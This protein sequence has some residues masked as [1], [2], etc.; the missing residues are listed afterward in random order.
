[1][2]FFNFFGKTL[3][4]PHTEL[5]DWGRLHPSVLKIKYLQ[6]YYKNPR[7]KC[8]SKKEKQP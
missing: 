8:A 4:Y 3:R 1:V 7:A 6:P 5:Q 2:S